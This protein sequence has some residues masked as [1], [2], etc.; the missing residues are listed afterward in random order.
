MLSSRDVP[1]R[2][3][4]TASD[5]QPEPALDSFTQIAKIDEGILAWHFRLFDRR[6]EEI[7]TV[8]RAFRGFGREVSGLGV[9][10]PYQTSCS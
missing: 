6:G 4:S 10:V 7:S 8:K 3:L 5:I 2:I 9:G 1:H